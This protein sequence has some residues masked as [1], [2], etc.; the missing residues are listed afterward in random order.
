MMSQNDRA[1]AFAALEQS[2]NALQDKNQRLHDRSKALEEENRTLRDENFQLVSR[3][4]KRNLEAARPTS[5][6]ECA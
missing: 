6:S 5:S 4:A 3:E 1:A 2:L